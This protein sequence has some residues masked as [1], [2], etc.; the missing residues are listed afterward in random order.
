M[1][2]AFVCDWCLPRFGGLE[3][4]LADLASALDRA[5]HPVHI[6]TAAP[7]PDSAAGTPVTRLGGL[8]MPWFGFTFSARQFRELHEAL[9]AGSYDVVHVHSSLIA[10]LAYGGAWISAREGFPTA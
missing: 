10:P 8:R 3:L 6:Y 9:C 7:G 4:Q 2:I 1:R 5:G